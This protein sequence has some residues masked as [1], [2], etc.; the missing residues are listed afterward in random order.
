MDVCLSLIHI[1]TH[2]WEKVSDIDSVDLCKELEQIGVKTIVYTDISVSYTHLDV[3]K[4]QHLDLMHLLEK[5]T[6]NPAKLYNLDRG[7]IKEGSF[8]DIVI[9]N[10][11]EKWEVKDFESKA[12]NT[13]FIG[14]VLDGKIKYTICEGKVVYEG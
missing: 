9:F 7:Y 3:Y 2:G 14:E 13:P 10:P 8:A 12:T 1:S 4:R 6:I 11:D 5:M